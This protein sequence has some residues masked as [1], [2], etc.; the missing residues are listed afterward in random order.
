MHTSGSTG[1]PKGVAIPHRA[2]VRLVRGASFLTVTPDDVFL[3]LAPLSFDASVLELWGSLLNGARLVIAP[4]ELP[5][6]DE[7]AALL[8]RSKITTLWLTAGLF[9]QMVDAHPAALA[10]LRHLLAG[11]DVLSPAHVRR[12]P[13]HAR[14]PPR[15]QRVRPHREHHVHLLRGLPARGGARPDGAHRPAHLRHRGLPAGRGAPAGAGG[16]AGRAV[17]RRR[18][19]GAGLSGAARSDRR[20]LRPLSVRRG[21]AALSHRRSSRAGCPAASSSSPAAWTSR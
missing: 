7:L 20:A 15:H 11:G 5:S 14:R 16:G 6:L 3:Q 12:A 21:R 8:V 9:H 4:P 13:R 2:V 17:H 19:P 1:E 10:G 18:R